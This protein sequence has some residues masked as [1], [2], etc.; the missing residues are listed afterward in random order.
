MR[1]D[2]NKYLS[3][4]FLQF[5]FELTLAST[6]LLGRQIKNITLGSPESTKLNQ[7][8][9]SRLKGFSEE[10]INKMYE[11]RNRVDTIVERFKLVVEVKKGLK[12]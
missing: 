2:A 9:V 4:F 1:T 10:E 12:D 3:T 5:R 8:L 7:I 11:V 6:R